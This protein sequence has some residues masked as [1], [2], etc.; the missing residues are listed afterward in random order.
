MLVWPPALATLII[1]SY[2]SYTT[3]QLAQALPLLL[4]QLN[5]AFIWSS[6]AAHQIGY[7][8]LQITGK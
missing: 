4:C 6:L 1:F 3:K 7:F 8:N 5:M 2:R